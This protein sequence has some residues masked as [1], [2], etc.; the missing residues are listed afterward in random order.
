MKTYLYPEKKDWVNILKRPTQEKANLESIVASVF[1]D[2]KADGD[3]ALKAYTQKFDGATLDSLFVS[4]SELKNAGSLIST[5]L[6]DAI[7]NAARNIKTFHETQIS[8][9]ERV[10]TQPGVECWRKTTA[11][12][13]VGLYIPGGTAPLFSTVLMLAIPANIPG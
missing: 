3:K 4:K 12:D 1:N 5:E 9:E 8:K 11:I 2:I 7:D 6:K 10:I 13:K